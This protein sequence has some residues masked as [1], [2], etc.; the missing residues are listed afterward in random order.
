MAI[1]LYNGVK[2]PDIPAD[3]Q[4]QYPY[5][6]ISW[7][8][9]T[10]N[11]YSM[12][13]LL[14]SDAPQVC[15]TR[16]YNL[17]P[18]NGLTDLSCEI[19]SFLENPSIPSYVIR[20]VEIVD[21]VAQWVDSMP[22][23]SA[24]I[25]DSGIFLSAPGSEPAGTVVYANHDINCYSIDYSTWTVTSLNTVYD[26]DRNVLES[27]NGIML[28]KISDEILNQFPYAMIAKTTKISVGDE[29]FNYEYVLIACAD[30]F[31]YA[32]PEIA[33]SDYPRIGS[34]GEDATAYALT[35]GLL[36]VAVRQSN[37]LDLVVSE[38]GKCEILWSNHDIMIADVDENNNPVITDKVYDYASALSMVDYNGNMLRKI[39]VSKYPYAGILNVGD[40]IMLIY[41]SDKYV[42]HQEEDAYINI[43]PME[44]LTYFYRTEPYGL[45]ELSDYGNTVEQ[46]RIPVSVAQ[47]IW[48]NY[49]IMYAEYDSEGNLVPT[50]EVYDYIVDFVDFNGVTLPEIPRDGFPSQVILS[51]RDESDSSGYILLLGEDKFSYLQPM[52]TGLMY[53]AIVS[54]GRVHYYAYKPGVME[55]SNW[56]LG[57]I[58]DPESFYF[59]LGMYEGVSIDI[60]WSNKDIMCGCVITES[61]ES[62]LLFDTDE[63]YFPPK[64]ES[65]LPDVSHASEYYAVHKNWISSVAAQVRRITGSY[66][67]MTCENIESA[68]SDFG[69]YKQVF[70][71]TIKEID[72][73]LPQLI[74]P[75][76]FFSCGDLK[77][78]NSNKPI[79]LAQCAFQMCVSMESVDLPEVIHVDDKVFS[80]CSRLTHVNLPKATIFGDGV[81]ESCRSLRYVSLPEATGLGS[82]CFGFCNNLA[83]VDLPKVESI[84][85]S[86]FA[87]CEGIT[88]LDFQSLIS[89]GSDWRNEA[90]YQCT[91]LTALILRSEIMCQAL[92]GG[93]GMFGGTP[94]QA[95]TGY[96][97]V[98]ASLIDA[99][100]ADD[101]WSSYAAQFRAIEDYTVDGTITGEL[102]ETRI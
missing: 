45:W 18:E 102:D 96:I 5:I 28:P 68:L 91:N 58:Y 12:Y 86:A 24:F 51:L 62:A 93:N 74:F 76:T 100:K 81:F 13:I 85:Y 36:W 60:L 53:S 26:C 72:F 57:E 40:G 8:G 29:I 67:R 35:P 3:I 56:Y 14:A 15:Y 87:H 9:E 4:A 46:D 71:K 38:D 54:T 21:G 65:T 44:I 70:N 94:I 89:I 90:F 80:G 20:Y 39:P 49:D 1:E 41:A 55:S 75:F 31:A 84:D 6:T 95:G 2:L 25:G 73:E 66:T 47:V 88:K 79:V 22:G 37:Y 52:Y 78:V 98:P 82:Y 19:L 92:N 63:V 59:P 64:S 101:G 77:M 99:Y 7:V 69:R 61:A 27:Y 17:N 23:S 16:V 11:E 48:T 30:K 34:T 32:P 33:K 43:K 50:D 97:Y 83:E 10:T 42:Y